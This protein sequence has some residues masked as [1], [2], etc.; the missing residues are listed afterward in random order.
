MAFLALISL[1]IFDCR[2][3]AEVYNTV[4]RTC[5]DIGHSSADRAAPL[6]PYVAEPPAICVA[7]EFHAVP[8]WAVDVLGGN[9]F[10]WSSNPLLKVG[11]RTILQT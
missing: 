3:V 11:T 2:L 4:G 9:E 6:I 7:R 8:K 1:I 10:F 5:T